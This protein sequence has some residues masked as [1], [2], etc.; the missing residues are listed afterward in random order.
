VNYEDAESRL[1]EYASRFNGDL[2][3]DNEGSIVGDF[4]GMMNK[5]SKDLEGGKIVF[6]ED[7]VEA[8]YEVTG[9]TK[10]RNF[11][12]AAMNTFNLLM[13][14]IVI[15]IFN[16]DSRIPIYIRRAISHN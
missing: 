6:Y 3:I 11:A 14:I 10:G 4:T 15:N 1:A 5:V 16:S 7:E 8:P 2:Y 13:S 12:I 9:N